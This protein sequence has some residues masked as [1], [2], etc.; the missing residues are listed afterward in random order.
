MAEIIKIALMISAI[1]IVCYSIQA[2]E[3]GIC[4]TDRFRTEYSGI[5]FCVPDGGKFVGRVSGIAAIS[6][7]F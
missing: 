3:T 1:S 6:R 5:F 7:R 4:I 2:A